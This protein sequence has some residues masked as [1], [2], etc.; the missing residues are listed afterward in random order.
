MRSCLEGWIRTICQPFPSPHQIQ[1][2]QN[3]FLSASTAGLAILGAQYWGKRD[4]KTLDDIFSMAIRICGIVSVLFFVACAFFPKYLMLIFTNEPVLIDYGVSYLRIAAFSYLLTGFSQCYI[5]MMKISEH[6]GSAAAVSSITVVLNILLN[7][8]FIYGAFGIRSMNVRGAALATLIARI[9]ELLLAVIF[10]YRPGFIRLK[11]HELFV[12]NKQL[13]KDFMKCS[14]PILGASLVWG[15]GFTSYS[16]FMGH[17]GT[18]AAAANS[19]AAVVRD[20]ICCL[21]A[22]ISSA[23]GIMVGNELGAGNLKRGKT[24]GIRLLKLSVVCGVIM[25]ILMAV[26]APVI[27]YFVKLTPQAGVYLKQ[28]FVVLA[29]YMIGR[30]MNEVIINGIFG[31][32]GDT[33]FDMYSLAV[34]MWGIAIPLAVAGTYF[35]NW[36]VVVVYACTCVDEV[37]KIPWTLIH[38]KKYKWVKDLTR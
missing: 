6:A 25:T 17:L 23:A 5:V 32:G 18:D 34:T 26:S 19:V 1:F 16:S 7:A 8:I 24:Y 21:S 29:L 9:V 28:M 12:R 15:I 4:I 22:G 2:I 13:S 30:S 33:M 31:S 35:L 10:S 14:G 20:I 38:F 37:G 36:P 11:V 3:M 27:L